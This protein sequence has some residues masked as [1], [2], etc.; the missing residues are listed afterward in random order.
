[1][2]EYG[3]GTPIKSCILKGP[4]CLKVWYRVQ[5]TFSPLGPSTRDV[6]TL[7]FHS[8]TSSFSSNGL[9][10]PPFPIRPWV[11]FEPLP[12]SLSLSVPGPIPTPLPS[13]LRIP[14]HPSPNGESLEEIFRR[15]PTTHVLPVLPP[16][17]VPGRPSV[18][19]NVPLSNTSGLLLLP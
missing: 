11:S 12:T 8:Y 17:S 4:L 6:F 13:D 1:M 9:Q 7:S 15:T 2:E 14:S 16:T 5:V 3:N 10:V 19:V 18:V